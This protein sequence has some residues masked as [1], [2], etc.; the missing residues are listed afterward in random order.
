MLVRIFLKKY[1]FLK[2]IKL[3][4]GTVIHPNMDEYDYFWGVEVGL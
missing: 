4:K 1:F 2:Q 3:T